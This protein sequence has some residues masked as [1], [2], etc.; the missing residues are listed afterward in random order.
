MSPAGS[1]KEQSEQNPH[2]LPEF[3]VVGNLARNFIIDLNHKA[4]D[5]IPGGSA[6]FAAAGIQC[7]GY[8]VGIVSEVGEDYP[9]DWLERSYHTGFDVRGVR[10]LPTSIDAREFYAGAA[11]DSPIHENPVPH[12][13]S[14][15]LPFPKSL[16][17]YAYEAKSR[18]QDPNTIYPHGLG[19]LTPQDYAQA[20]AVHLCPMNYRLQVQIPVTLHKCFINTVT[21]DPSPDYMIPKNWDNI[22]AL[23]KSTTAF[24]PSEKSLVSLFQGRSTD[25]WEMAQALAAF[26]C[27]YIVIRR[28]SKG[29]YLYDGYAGKRYFVPTYPLKVTNLV[30]VSDAF[31][32]GFLAAIKKTYDPLEACLQGN[33]SASLA[34]QSPNPLFLADN[35]PG[36]TQARLDSLRTKVQQL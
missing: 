4:Y 27:E 7:W 23:L 25:L 2:P 8:P 21:I 29:Q 33:I 16:L 20:T 11:A 10:V 35:L 19:N 9:L 15:H 12:Y 5:D 3:L 13:S 36:F 17:G 32:G 6:L 1:K 14:N 34:M 22:P 24:L 28:G 30:G 26:G 18:L 31:C